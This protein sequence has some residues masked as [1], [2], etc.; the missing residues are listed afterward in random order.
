MATATASI[1]IP[2]LERL[3]R[4]IDPFDDFNEE[5][6]SGKICD[7]SAADVEF[8]F[9]NKQ[10]SRPK[11]VTFSRDPSEKRVEEAFTTRD[12][13][14][15]YLERTLKVEAKYGAFSG[16]FEAT[17]GEDYSAFTE[18]TAALLKFHT[19]LW[20]LS[21]DDDAPLATNFIAELAK[22]P[23]ELKDESKFYNFFRTFGVY[24]I[25][26]LTM[27][28]AMDYAMLVDRSETTRTSEL[29]LKVR[30]EYDVFFTGSASQ[31]KKEEVKNFSKHRK[32]IMKTRG[33]NAT[34]LGGYD[35]DNLDKDWSAQFTQWKDSIASEPVVASMKLKRID[36][37]VRDEKKRAA[38]AAAID[39]YLGG[40]V[41]VESNWASSTIVLT[42]EAEAMK[43]APGDNAILRTV[44]VDKRTLKK[45]EKRFGAPA[46]GASDQEFT[47][48]W[49]SVNTHLK[50]IK[51]RDTMLL[52]ATERWP[53][54]RRYF[55][56]QAAK[57]A[58]IALGASPQNI[59]RWSRLTDN[60]V[61]CPVAGV[62]YVLAGA[63][64]GNGLEALAA[65]F[66]DPNTTLRPRVRVSA[67]LPRST[68][69]GQVRLVADV[70]PLEDM[71]TELYQIQSKRGD[72]PVLAA[73]T[74]GSNRLLLRKLD[75]T[76]PEQF[77]FMES[78]IERYGW[79]PYRLI[80]YLTL[81]CVQ[82]KRGGGE[83]TTRQFYSEDD[84]LWDYRGNDEHANMLMLYWNSEAWNLMNNGSLAT[85]G[86]W[87]QDGMHWRR[88]KRLPA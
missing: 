18:K 22:L 88:I 27:G 83:A 84:V 66:G 10:Y 58:L 28:G 61:P 31:Q 9:R 48:F 15:S 72:Q 26:E 62:S 55:P 44:T 59:E 71:Q 40:S 38:I 21:L 86:T 23:D 69:T 4:G 82:G 70:K 3:G 50:A 11:S 65:G 77:W 75:P 17:F 45:D 64:P 7:T 56:S 85:T 6:S 81:G 20:T 87:L 43:I 12:E 34:P 5:Q 32:T 52:F 47:N 16:S 74:A 49:S 73:D 78:S 76:K 53:R 63:G 14:Q 24:V 33:G 46:L 35:P 60:V 42:E 51:P 68:A 25:T 39:K 30:A 19:T 29:K 13:Y 54:D 80:N 8:E 57:E 1:P 36:S 2:G 41:L 79:R 37:F 67:V